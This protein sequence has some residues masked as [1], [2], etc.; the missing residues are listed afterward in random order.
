MG[1]RYT[2]SSNVS[3][4]VGAT[5]ILVM[6]AAILLACNE[7]PSSLSE[8]SI[9]SNLSRKAPPDPSLVMGFEHARFWWATSGRTATSGLHVE[10]L[11][12]LAVGGGGWRE[13]WSVPIAKPASVSATVA[14]DLRLP[15]L[16]SNRW[17][18]GQ[19]Q[20]FIDAASAGI[21]HEAV[22]AKELTGL[23]LG[24]FVTIEHQLP[25]WIFDQLSGREV[26]DLRFIIALN[27]PWDA[28]GIYH[29]D[30]LR[31]VGATDPCAGVDPDDGNPCTTDVC[32]PTTGIVT[33]DPVADGTG[34]PDDDL[35][36]GDETCLGGDCVFGIA[37]TVDDDNP[38]TDDSCDPAS[39]VA[40]VPVADGTACSDADLCNGDETCTAGD[41]MP[42]TPLIVDDANPCTADACD[43]LTGVAN[44]PVA[45]GTACSDADLC[46]GDETCSAGNCMPG[47]P[48]IV[49]DGNPC[50]ADTCDPMSGIANVAVADGTACPD[51]DLCNGDE[52]CT[53]GDCTPG[54]A[55]V[56]DDGNP[57]TADACDP[58]TGVANVP[59]ADG[60]ACA[61]ADVC[62]GGETCSAG[63]CTPGVPLL[64]DDG[65]PCTADACDPVTGVTHLPVADGAAC[66]DADACNG[67]EICAAGNCMPGLPP[68]VDDGNPCTADACDPVTGVTHLPVADGTDCADTDVCNGAETCVDGSCVPGAPL[69]VDDGNPCTADA[70][71]PVT[72]VANFPVADGTA[73]ADADVCNG[74]ETCSAGACTPGLPLLVDDGNPCTA[75]ACDP[76]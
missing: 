55:L 73:C 12:S 2:T 1:K 33:H 6:G 69:V 56:V 64:V 50:T 47:T 30:H 15:F 38:C 14:Y 13:L 10:G 53:A 75:D 43:P 76:V 49:D 32:D 57:C 46:N 5:T 41:C 58:A 60:T 24:R 61:D 40:N 59:L 23:P 3:R 72:G 21:H 16:Q 45:D 4:R 48:L 71:D 68:A 63:T 25:Q 39:G 70:C 66:A 34:C 8:D 28:K 26:T 19:T 54:V 22:G 52:T 35:C 11:H 74:S 67:D 36:N 18:Y 7:R 20:L 65:N 17:W 51:A 31:F 42:G 62:N 44:V 27:V 9:A 29:F 37:P